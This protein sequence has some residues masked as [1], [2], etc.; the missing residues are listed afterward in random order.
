MA[1]NMP[2]LAITLLLF[3]AASVADAQTPPPASSP[4][5]V[6]HAARLLDVET[7]NIV[8]PGEILVEGQ[9]IVEAG[10]SVKRPSGAQVLDLGDTTLLPGL[11]DAHVHL[12]L[13]PGA[14]D[15]QTVVES[16]PE[17]TI[18]AEIAARDDLMAGFTAERDMGTE[19]AGSADAAVRNA[20]DA[21]LIPGPRLRVSGNAISI[22]GGHEDAIEYNPEAHIKSNA[23]YANGSAELISVIRQQLKEGA[24]FIKI[25]ETGKDAE[26]AGR[27]VSTYQYTLAELEA[28]VKETA[29]MGTHVAVHATGEPGTLYAAQAGVASIDHAYQL[30]SE[31]MRLMREKKIFAVPTFT[32][33]EYFADHASTPENAAREKALQEFH[34]QQFRLQVAAGVPMAVGSDV[35]P[36]PHGTQAREFVLMVQYGMTPL[37]VLQADLLNGAR[38]LDWQEQIGRLKAGYFADIIAVPGNPLKDISVLQKVSFVMK[39]GVVYRKSSAN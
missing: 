13:H 9:H 15:L 39:N 19:G 16:V 2:S 32:I 30:S 17:R 35:G 34:I 24:D 37:A 1:P 33:T 11:I 28:A 3:L 6:L 21:G 5:I 12:F 29:R 14:E 38:L 22:L 7:G 31:T 20:I 23:T 10:T 25:Y 27:F 8:T 18:L 36:F 4:N 26:L